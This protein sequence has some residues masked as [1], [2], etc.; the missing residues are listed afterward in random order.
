[1]K[2]KLIFNDAEFNK[3]KFDFKEFK[4]ITVA[5]L[6]CSDFSTVE[7]ILAEAKKIKEK[8]GNLDLRLRYRRYKNDEDLNE[9]FDFC[10]E[11]LEEPY[12]VCDVKGYTRK[13]SEDLAEEKAIQ[14]EFKLLQEENL[15]QQI[16]MKKQELAV[17]ERDLKK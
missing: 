1:M 4:S 9:D 11:P 17:L 15:K 16:Q 14:E 2:E 13:T 3:S 12:W 10:D 7:K 8:Y 6:V 5:T